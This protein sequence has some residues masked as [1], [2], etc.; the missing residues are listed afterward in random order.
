MG[1]DGDGDAEDELVWGM[2]WGLSGRVEEGLAFRL[3]LGLGSRFEE[4]VMVEVVE[5]DFDGNLAL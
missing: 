5:V 3:G 1:F 4:V 2:V